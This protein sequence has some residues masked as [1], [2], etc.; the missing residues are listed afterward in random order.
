MDGNCE[1]SY[2][3]EIEGLVLPNFG[4]DWLIDHMCTDYF[5]VA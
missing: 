4:Q 1:I 3:K 5:D 2:R